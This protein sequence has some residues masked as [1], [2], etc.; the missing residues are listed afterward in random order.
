MGENNFAVVKKFYTQAF[1]IKTVD[2]QVLL[3]INKRGATCNCFEV[4]SS[5]VWKYVSSFYRHDDGMQLQMKKL[6]F[7]PKLRQQSCKKQFFTHE[8]L[9]NG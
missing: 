2:T 9:D 1:L 8:K 5:V 7:V 6:F 4:D 3:V